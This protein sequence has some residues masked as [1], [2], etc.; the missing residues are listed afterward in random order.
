MDYKVNRLF[1][2]REQGGL[3]IFDI[4]NGNN[5][6]TYGQDYHKFFVCTHKHFPFPQDSERVYS[7]PIGCRDKY[8]SYTE[9]V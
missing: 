9:M 3:L 6:K 4:Q 7:R 2:T 8:I 1:F 5:Q